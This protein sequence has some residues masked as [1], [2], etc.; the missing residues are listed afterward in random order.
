MKKEVFWKMAWICLQIF[1][2][3]INVM[4]IAS[5]KATNFDKVIFVIAVVIF[6]VWWMSNI[7]AKIAANKAYKYF[8]KLYEFLQEEVQRCAQFGGMDQNQ[9]AMVQRLVEITKEEGDLLKEYGN[10]LLANKWLSQK[11]KV[12]VKEMMNQIDLM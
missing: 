6:A 2:I 12:K 11:R 8:L 7:L 1:V 4:L 9:Q 10:K 3:A 5:G